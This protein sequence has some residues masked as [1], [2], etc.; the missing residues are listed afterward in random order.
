MKWPIILY[1]ILSKYNKNAELKTKSNVLIYR[2]F[3]SIVFM[4]LNLFDQ[5]IQKKRNIITI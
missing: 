2:C 1:T 3:G 4:F 5:K